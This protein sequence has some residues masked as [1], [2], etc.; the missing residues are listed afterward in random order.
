MNKFLNEI[1]KNNANPV[2]GVGSKRYFKQFYENIGNIQKKKIYLYGASSKSGKTTLVDYLHILIP[3][4]EG[5]RNIKYYYF[6]WEIDI[7]E[8]LAS[9]CS[10]FL[11]HRFNLDLSADE[12]SGT[13]RKLN[14]HEMSC[15]K[16]VYEKE[17]TQL[18]GRYNAK[19]EL[20]S[21]GIIEY[22]E[23]RM[24]PYE[25]EAALQDIAKA[26]GNF[27]KGFYQW[28][29]VTQHV[30]IIVDHIGKTK[31]TNSLVKS[32]IDELTDNCV[33]YRN[34]CHFTFILISQF[35]RSQ[36]AIDRRGLLT[37]N[38]KPEKSDFKDSSNGAEDCNFL[39]AIFNPLLFNELDRIKIGGE[40]F[41][42]RKREELVV[43]TGF[44]GLYLLES[45]KKTPFELPF[46]ITGNS[47]I[48]PYNPNQ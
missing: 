9:F 48:E 38:L 17:L 46:V 6:A 13:E 5:Y 32:A 24:N 45:R 25:F 27:E 29:D 18:F 22:I 44:R 36:G 35:N 41:T 14:E 47:S 21:P 33:V 40:V 2:K 8:K 28:N 43:P 31:K 26:H 30:H 10:F 15:I 7:E 39:F 4:L 20:V 12:I 19:G 11:K 42:L 37:M 3:Y 1:E 16:D 23:T 34:K